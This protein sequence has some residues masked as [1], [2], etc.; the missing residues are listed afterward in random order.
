MEK[1]FRYIQFPLCLIQETYQNSYNGLN[2]ILDY[3]IVNYAKSFK[4]DIK[5][6]ARQ[7]MYAYYRNRVMIQ[8]DLYEMFDGFLND[9]LLSTDEDYN[10]FSGARFYPEDS[11]NELLKL[12]ESNLKF[13]EGAIFRY[14][15]TQAENFLGINDFNIDSTIM[16]YNKGLSLKNSFER[17][18]GPD[19]CP[20]IK[21]LQLIEFRD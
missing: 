9:G 6:V 11:I 1:E 21:P 3:G 16:N 19:C 5:E 17:I 14:Q 12:F 8:D 10:G 7:L 13:K 15:I 2:V 18:Y 20:S 4:Y